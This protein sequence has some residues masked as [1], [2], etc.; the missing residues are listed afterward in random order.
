MSAVVNEA[1]WTAIADRIKGATP[2]RVA[3]LAG[4]STLFASEALRVHKFLESVEDAW[5]KRRETFKKDGIAKGNP[6]WDEAF[7][8]HQK[9]MSNASSYMAKMFEQ[10]EKAAS[11][12]SE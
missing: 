3:F 9:V 11:M 6:I 7:S 1:I 12:S 2:E 10:A 5:A 8:N 4:V